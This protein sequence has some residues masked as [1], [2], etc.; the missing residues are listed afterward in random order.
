MSAIELHPWG[1]T[2]DDIERPDRLIFDFDPDPSVGFDRVVEAALAL[3]KALDKAGL[4]SFPKT[5]GGKG[6]HV[7]VPIRPSLGWDEAKDFCHDVARWMVAQDPKRFTAE[8]SKA[9]RRGRIFVDYL[10]N[11]RGATAVAP[12]SPRARPGATFAMPLAWKD[13]KPGL[14]PK[15]YTVSEAPKFTAQ[16]RAGWRGFFDVDQ[17]VDAAAKRLFAAKT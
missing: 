3:R 7:V 8:M 16:A 6:L 13:V 5:T 14:D 2:L 12:F 11:G 17:T 9:K 1:S 4:K 10:R 15:R